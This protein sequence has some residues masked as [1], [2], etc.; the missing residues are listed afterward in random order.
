[1]TLAVGLTFQLKGYYFVLIFSRLVTLF[2]S[3]CFHHATIFQIS[4]DANETQIITAGKHYLNRP[5]VL[6]IVLN[7]LFH[8]FR[9]ENC[10][11]KSSL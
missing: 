1:M 6:E 2:C 10:A 11:S 3:L 8:I 7:D 4:G 9:Y 5:H